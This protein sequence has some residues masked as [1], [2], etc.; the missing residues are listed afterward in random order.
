MI[1]QLHSLITLT[2][3]MSLYQLLPITVRSFYDQ[4]QKQ[5]RIM[6]I[7]IDIKNTP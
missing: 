2:I 5:F 1:T 4:G 6:S 7:N 3:C